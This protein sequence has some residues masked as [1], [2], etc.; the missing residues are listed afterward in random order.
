MGV[1]RTGRKAPGVKRMFATSADNGLL[2]DGVLINRETQW[3]SSHE[4]ELQ[5]SV[6]VALLKNHHLSYPNQSCSK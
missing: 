2:V 5:A 6:I 3:F 1:R 4:V